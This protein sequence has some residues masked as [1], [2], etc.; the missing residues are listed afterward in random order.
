MT[1]STN[2]KPSRG[3]PA[4]ALVAVLGCPPPPPAP[5]GSSGSTDAH[6]VDPPRSCVDVTT[7][8]GVV[9]ID[10][11]GDGAREPFDAWCDEN[12]WIL[13]AKV[14]GSYDVEREAFTTDRQLAALL[15]PEVA[16]DGL[17]NF[18]F[19]RF[20]SYGA[21]WTLRAVVHDPNASPPWAQHTYFRAREGAIVEPNELGNN[22]YGKSTPMRLE[23]LT[24]AVSGES[25]LAGDTNRTWLP[26]GPYER[27]VPP[28]T[29]PVSTFYMFGQ[30]DEDPLLAGVPCID[31]GGQS[32]RCTVLA[33][34]LNDQQGIDG[35]L[36]VPSGLV[37]YRDGVAHEWGRAVTYWIRDDRPQMPQDP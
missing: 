29:P 5:A 26:V 7:A 3:W 35:S 17:A 4:A 13:I 2:L 15:D 11:D 34:L 22:W 28:L 21:T 8:P 10:P 25:A 9:T 37:S 19:D 18:A 24:Y 20:E 6:S 32:A 12:G 14:G 31:Q 23:Y 36:G 27:S 1:A 30:Y 33:G 16:P